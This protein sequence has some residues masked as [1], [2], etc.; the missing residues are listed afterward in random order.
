M[1]VIVVLVLGAGIGDMVAAD[2]DVEDVGGVV[3]ECNCCVSG[4]VGYT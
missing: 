3:V 2:A 4:V 1:A